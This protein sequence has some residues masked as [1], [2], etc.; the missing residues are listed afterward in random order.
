MLI[1]LG[2]GSGWNKNKVWFVCLGIGILTTHAPPFSVQVYL[3]EAHVIRG[4]DDI[5]LQCNEGA[6]EDS[7]CAVKIE[8]TFNEPCEIGP[9]LG[10]SP[11]NPVTSIISRIVT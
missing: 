1:G 9:R 11:Y 5:F 4:G 6:N 3:Q 8:N 7:W 10:E 2:R